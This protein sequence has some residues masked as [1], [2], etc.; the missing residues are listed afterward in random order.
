M[1]ERMLPPLDCDPLFED[2]NEDAMMEH[3]CGLKA[4]CVAKRRTR[5]RTGDSIAVSFFR[6]PF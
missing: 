3:N 6:S 5:W 4:T 2:S 1:A